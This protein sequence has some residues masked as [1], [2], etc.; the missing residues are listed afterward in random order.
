APPALRR[1]IGRWAGQ[2]RAR[3]LPLTGSDLVEIGLSGPAVGRALLRIRS[4]YLDGALRTR[5]E[6]L[7]LAREL[8]RGR[9]ARRPRR[10]KTQPRR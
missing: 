1:R 3:R 7:A 10:P 4:A 6:A 5:E 2:D 9:G 8:S